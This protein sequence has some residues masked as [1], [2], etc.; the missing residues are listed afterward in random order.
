[1]G[2]SSSR[3]VSY[4]RTEETRKKLRY[5]GVSAVFI[6]IG[7]GLIQVLGYWLNDYTAASLLQGAII[8]FP[9]FFATKHF[10]WRLSIGENLRFHVL[11]F[12]VTLMLG[13]LLTTF[14][15]YLAENLLAGQS[16]LVRGT[17]VL[18]AQLLGLCVNFISR[19]LILDRWLFKLADHSPEDGHETVGEIPTRSERDH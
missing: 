9:L 17:G 16:G 7:Q 18:F 11:V 13:I 6:P 14:L 10:V 2:L 19:Y 5:L 3:V 8:A 12:W 1:M 15:T 4:A